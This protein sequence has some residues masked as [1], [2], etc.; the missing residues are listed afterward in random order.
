M[1]SSYFNNRF[2]FFATN[3]LQTTKNKT[4]SNN[5]MA[6]LERFLEA[7]YQE[8]L[9]EMPNLLRQE[10]IW[11]ELLETLKRCVNN[12]STQKT[13]PWHPQHKE[14]YYLAKLFIL[15]KLYEE[16]HESIVLTNFAETLANE[17]AEE[18]RETVVSNLVEALR[19]LMQ[20][21]MDYSPTRLANQKN[22][23]EM[24]KEADLNEIN[25]LI[26]KFINF[27]KDIIEFCKQPA[28]AEVQ[29]IFDEA[30]R[31]IKRQELSINSNPGL[32]DL[33]LGSTRH[34]GHELATLAKIDNIQTMQIFCNVFKE[35]SEAIAANLEGQNTL[36]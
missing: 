9:S 20:Q 32:F 15:W 13:L 5:A 31:E 16:K 30:I 11:Q 3:K 29:S 36:S 2:G 26:P 28:G 12:R 33:A 7:R 22:K 10:L 6:E 14:Y 4:P 18:R 27:A 34:K 21:K 8:H 1:S 19:N 35:K 17:I 24:K 25:N 23:L